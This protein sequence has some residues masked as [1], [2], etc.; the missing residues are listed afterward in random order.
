MKLIESKKNLMQRITFDKL[1]DL[2]YE[3]IKNNA[4]D[5]FVNQSI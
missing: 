4:G 3:T 5:I 2:L 1:F